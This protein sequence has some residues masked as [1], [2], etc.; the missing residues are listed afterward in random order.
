M[1]D[2]DR[3]HGSI[4][5]GQFRLIKDDRSL[6]LK[7]VTRTPP[8]L[9]ALPPQGA[10]LLF[11]GRNLDA[12][13]KKSGKEW[14][15]EDGP[16]RW[17]L[18]EG[19]A[20]EVVPGSDCIMTHQKLGDCK[21]HVE[22]RT[23]GVPTNS[24]VF[25]QDR[26][27]VNINETYGRLDLSP[28]AGF[29]NCTENVKPRVRPCLPPLAW[30]A[31]DIDF[32]APRFDATGRKIAN[33]RATVLF[34]GVKIYDNQSLDQPHG[35]A[36][37]LGEAP[38]GPLMLQEHGMP[39]QFR[40]V[41]LV[42]TGTDAAN[43]AQAPAAV[44]SASGFRHPGVLVNRAQLDLI[45]SRVAAGIE[46]QKSACEAAKSSDLA[47]RDYPPHPWK[48]C[49][50]GPRSNP[51][52]GCKDEQRDSEAAYA[53]ALLWYMTGDKAYAENAIEIMNAWASTLTGGHK[54]ANG[55]VQ[56]AWCGEVWPRAAEIIRYTYPGWSA[57]EVVKF[58]QMLATQYVPSLVGGSGEKRQQ[59][60]FD[61]R[62]LD[63]YRRVQRRPQHV[64]TGG[65]DVARPGAGLHLP[66]HRWPRADQA[67]RLGYGH[68]GEQGIH[69]AV[70]RRPV[71]GDLP[72]FAACQPGAVGHGQCGRNRPAAG[73]RP[74]RRA[75]QAH[76]GR[77]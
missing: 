68:L 39:V 59:R 43:R 48:T 5:K 47:A 62:G 41:W 57:A 54:L 71:A 45:K 25:L 17:K 26:Y 19:D 42:E 20:V 74:L 7:H 67:G 16:A 35:A 56:A 15:K 69:D 64:R 61:E 23:L 8:T 65:E 32:H 13:A 30:Q 11:D 37:R 46:P 63:Q 75:G 12:W 34:N 9:G 53:Q 72:R 3:W 44:V 31:F 51:D 10:I 76:H 66:E 52:L 2:G 1:F 27:E 50:C 14:L 77:P 21:L 70:G 73:P 33:A 22:F 24:G 38:T 4:E 28:N 60:T 55:P 29:D 6:N 58:Q 18:V 36:S 40:N 49:E